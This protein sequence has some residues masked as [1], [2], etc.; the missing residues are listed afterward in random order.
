MAQKSDTTSEIKKIEA[1]KSEPK[2]I[3]LL[4]SV[5]KNVIKIILYRFG[6]VLGLWHVT[7][8]KQN[9]LIEKK[10]TKKKHRYPSVRK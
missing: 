2:N 6:G 8:N 4:T 3:F 7:P 1:E 9:M 10:K 5:H